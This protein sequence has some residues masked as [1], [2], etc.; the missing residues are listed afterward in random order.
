MRTHKFCE[1]MFGSLLFPMMKFR[2]EPCSNNSV[3]IDCKSGQERKS[4]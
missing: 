2:L 4:L 3:G 1:Q